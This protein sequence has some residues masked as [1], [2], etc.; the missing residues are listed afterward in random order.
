VVI[1]DAFDPGDDV[2]QDALGVFALHT[3]TAH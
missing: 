1:V 3:G 2:T